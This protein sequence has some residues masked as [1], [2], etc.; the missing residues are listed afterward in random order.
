MDRLSNN[1]AL[2]SCAI[3]HT[4]KHNICDIALIDLMVVLCTDRA[5]R[6]RMP[7][8]ATYNDFVRCESMFEHALNRKFKEMQPMIIN[9]MSMLLMSG[10]I[11]NIEG[12]GVSLSM[13]GSKMADEISGINSKAMEEFITASNHLVNLTS[14]KDVLVMYNDLKIV[15]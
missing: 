13:E 2:L 8:Y 4:M 9:A 11:I 6:Q 7:R 1:E 10:M 12:N 14:S 3:I 15:L 5:I